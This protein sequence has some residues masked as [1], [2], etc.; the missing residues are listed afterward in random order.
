MADDSRFTERQLEL[1]SRVPDLEPDLPLGFED[2]L[3]SKSDEEIEEILRKL[4]AQYERARDMHF[5]PSRT[6]KVARSLSGIDDVLGNVD[7]ALALP[8]ARQSPGRLM[9]D[10]ALKAGRRVS[11]A[12]DRVGMRE[13]AQQMSNLDAARKRVREHQDTRQQ[14]RSGPNQP[15][16]T[17]TRDQLRTLAEDTAKKVLSEPGS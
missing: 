5:Q 13:L 16:Q 15:S 4:D 12:A 2:R 6:R 11:S 17:N 8:A 3:F 1:L 7:E 9:A 10:A 14:M